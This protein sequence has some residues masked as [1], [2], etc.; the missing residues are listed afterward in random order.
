MDDYRDAIASC[1]RQLRLSANLAD[2]AF[3]MQGE[4]HQEYLYNL[5]SEEIKCRKAARIG[6]LINSAGF[7]VQHNFAAFHPD[8]VQLELCQYSRQKKLKDY[9]AFL[10]SSSSFC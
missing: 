8:E 6:K 4:T 10:S 7:P 2:H 1:C 5:L 3:A 9:A